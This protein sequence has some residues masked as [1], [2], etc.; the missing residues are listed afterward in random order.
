MRFF[1]DRS[2]ADELAGHLLQHAGGS[3]PMLKLL[4]L[5]YLADRASLIETGFPITGDAIVAM[6][7]GPVLSTT[8]DRLKGTGGLGSISADPPASGLSSFAAAASAPAH[9]ASAPDSAELSGGRGLI[10]YE[11]GNVKLDAPPPEDGL[12]SDYEIEVARRVFEKFGHMS[13]QQL[14]DYLHRHAPEWEAPPTGS[15]RP[16]DPAAI[17]R[18]AGKSEDEIAAIAAQADYFYTVDQRLA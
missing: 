17:L 11:P 6:D 12:L 18:A 3:M 14:A 10:S 5:M 8:Y 4:K 9:A 16:I 2:K 15:S 1:Y 7:K 13:G